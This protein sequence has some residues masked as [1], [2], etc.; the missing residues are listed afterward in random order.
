MERLK[1]KK[2]KLKSIFY[3]GLCFC[4]LE[5]GFNFAAWEIAHSDCYDFYHEEGGNS[6]YYNM[7]KLHDHLKEF[8]LP[9][10]F[11]SFII[12]SVILSNFKPKISIIINSFIILIKLVLLIVYSINLFKISRNV[13]P[14]FPILSEICVIGNFIYYELLRLN[15]QKNN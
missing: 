8:I 3:C 12:I 9:C 13:I 15:I 10:V 6:E 14:I 4:C 1:K 2:S 11:L 7:L 5:V